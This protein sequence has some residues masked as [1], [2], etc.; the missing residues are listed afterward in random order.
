M[1]NHWI[2]IKNADAILIMGSNAAEH[3]P[4]SFKWVLR[5]KDKGAVVIHVD[6]KF[7]RTS[8]RS[9]FH[10]P[11]RSGTDIPVLGG[12]VK[13]ILEKGLYQK[14]YVVNNTNASFI[15]NKKY[16]FKDGLFSG[17]DA[18]KRAYD[19]SFWAFE[20]DA[21]GVPKKDK[22][23]Q[24][25]RCVFNLMKKHYDRY[26]L[27]TVSSVSGVSKENLLKLYKA[28]GATG[29]PAKSGTIMYA[30]GWTQH[31]VG[32]QNIRLAAILQ[33][34][35]GNIGVAG[36]GINALRGE[37][38][39]QGSTDHCIL[40]HILPGYMAVPNA[41]WQ[42]LAD[43]NKANT[44]ISHDPE[45]AN[46]WQNKPKYLASLLK[47][48]YGENATRENGFGYRMLPKV[49]P[50][51]DYSYLYIFD[52]MY[53]GKINGGFVFGTNPL[54]SAPNSNKNRAAVDQ[55][56]WLVVGELHHTETSDN[57]HR[58]GADP[59]KI[60]TEVFLLPSAHRVEKAG[61]VTNS[62]RWLLW[63]EMAK[64]PIGECRAMGEMIVD[65]MNKVR[66]LYSRQ[67]GAYPDPLLKMDWPSYY[68]P[69]D[70]AGRINGRF[71]VDTVVKGKT[72]KAGDQVPSFAALADNGA[73]MCLNWLYSGSYTEEGGNKARRRNLNQTAMQKNIGLFPNYSWCWP[74]NRRILYNRASVDLNGNPIAPQ[75]AVIKWTG[76][77]WEGDVPDGG[78][79]P[80]ATGKGRYPFIMQK[81]GFGQVFGPG[82]A[83]GPLPEH[84]EPI[85][86]PLTKNPFSAQFNN[87]CFKKASSEMDALAHPGDKRFPIVLTTYNVTEMWCGGGETRNTPNLLEAEPQ[88]YA[89]MSHELAREKGIENGD[90]VIIESARG[91]AEAIAM[92]TVRMTPF[93][94]EGKTVHL[95][96]MPFCYGW[97]TRG[98]GDATNRLTA[99]VGDPNTGIPEYK[100]VM[101]NVTKA[102]RLR[103]LDV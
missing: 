68:D 39:V 61:S 2:D 94:V 55:L 101:V 65:V 7:S 9:T 14:D 20:T 81:H 80:V 38:N 32:V 24:H 87:P 12:M 86:S 76:T 75:K 63:H 73:T 42:T 100:A 62:G 35:L 66:S 28:Y 67:N 74:V 21:S 3:H 93:K 53:N 45:S 31:T 16:G 10:I 71:L 91:T 40:W 85:E 11:L 43:Y 4:I 41:N 36:G 69:D 49:E 34:L 58:P 6:P 17:Y 57:W 84:Y 15:V 89:E 96:G 23:L 47:G 52:R 8:A 51:E 79:P 72:Y 99:S 46:W 95:I 82:R 44:P 90:P 19:K 103:E 29:T 56:D 54:Q 18:P 102:R 77:G 98:V 27:N 64:K 88:L 30:L 37:P 13:Y 59:N 92:V 22:T 1:T 83:D 97:T 50:G 78:W 26:D 48:W 60:K 70:M 25:P 5:A 33:L